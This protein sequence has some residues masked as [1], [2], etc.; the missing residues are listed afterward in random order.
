MAKAEFFRLFAGPS[1]SPAPMSYDLNQNESELD[2]R[3]LQKLADAAK[4]LRDTAENTLTYMRSCAMHIS[5]PMVPELEA[6]FLMAREKVVELSGGRKRR[7]EIDDRAPRLA[8][9]NAYPSLLARSRMLAG[10]TATGDGD[11]RFGTAEH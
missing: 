10:I 3:Q 6:N 4:F 1:G 2:S 5:H 9:R 7:F 8:A 11:R